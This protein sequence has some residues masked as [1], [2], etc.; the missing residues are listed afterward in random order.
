MGPELALE[1]RGP[2]VVRCLDLGERLGVPRDALPRIKSRGA[3]RSDPLRVRVISCCVVRGIVLV[4]VC[5]LTVRLAHAQRGQVDVE[6]RS[7]ET[8]G[9][10]GFPGFFDTG[11]VDRGHFQAD[12]LPTP[13]LRYGL[14]DE[15]SLRVSAVPLLGFLNG[16]WGAGVELR[17]RMW[18]DRRF[19]LVGTLAAT[20][21][22]FGDLPGNAE[23]DTDPVYDN[24]LTTAFAVLT[25]DW[26]ISPRH[27]LAVTALAGK[28]KFSAETPENG[29][30]VR[31][32]GSSDFSTFLVLATQTYFIRGVLGLQWGV[33]YAPYL[34]AENR[35]AGNTTNVDL[36]A[37]LRDA[38]GV[39]IVPRLGIFVRTRRWLMGVSVTGVIPSI[40][41]AQTW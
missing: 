17:H 11:T 15:A 13:G 10:D 21:V 18:S 1:V 39:A 9:F 34:H 20:L 4:V 5:V 29:G 22:N 33:G 32:A 8:S 36:E 41:L 16:G 35:G 19:N 26:R 37:A 31:V 14:T 30:K 6:R 23:M 12:Y 24:T 27:V 38:G 2:D 3:V 28:I 40:E 25:A 7:T